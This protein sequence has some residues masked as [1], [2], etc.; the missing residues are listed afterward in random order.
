MSSSVAILFLDPDPANGG[1]TLTTI[2]GISIADLSGPAQRKGGTAIV[3]NTTAVGQELPKFIMR[4]CFL[5]EPE[6]A[7]AVAVYHNNDATD[8]PTGALYAALFENNQFGN[9]MFLSKSGDGITIRNNLVYG[10]GAGI[11]A[12]LITG[13][14]NLLIDGNII[15]TAGGC[16]IIDYALAPIISNNECEQQVTN[17]E[18]NNAMIDLTGSSAEIIGAHILNNLVMANSGTGS[19]SLLRIANCTDALYDYN[20]LL[21]PTAYVPVIITASAINTRKGANNYI[22]SGG[23][24]PET[25]S[26]AGTRY[27]GAV[28]ISGN[29]GASIAAATT[30]YFT[31][32]QNSATELDIAGLFPVA[33]TVRNLRVI[34]SGGAPGAAQTYIFTLRNAAADTALTCTISGAASNSAQDV[35]NSAHF[36][37]GAAFQRWAIKIVTS[38]GA[39]ATGPISFSFEFVPD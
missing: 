15:T 11:K 5:Q 29:N 23:A 27:R 26:G 6:S 10:A 32:G 7:S 24:A 33:G 1:T 16:I 22:S 35:T 38:A 34:T 13:A 30:N 37:A 28:S 21:T 19:P 18:A 17:T 2:Q 3:L 14:G 12:D 31:D 25:D 9:G 36:D 20:K 8:N 39:N 4:D